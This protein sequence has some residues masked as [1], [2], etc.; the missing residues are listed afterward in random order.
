MIEM[1]I[2]EEFYTFC[3]GLHQDSSYVYGPEPEDWIRGALGLL[4]KENHGALGSFLVELLGGEHSDAELN[5]IYFSTD[6]EVSVRG[7]KGIRE[8]LE[9]VR[10]SIEADAS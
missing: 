5:E 4:R 2:P 9:M 10:D 1:K 8:F 3:L 6:A 7:P